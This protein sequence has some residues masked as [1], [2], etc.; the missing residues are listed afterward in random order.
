M[1]RPL[2]WPDWLEDVWAKSAEKGAGGSPE[3]L[4]QHT[5][6]VLERF[7][8]LA[9]LRPT[10]PQ[11]IGVPRLWHILFWAIMIH[12]FGKAACGFQ[13]RLR[14]GPR[15]PYRH[16]VLSLAFI[17][18]IA[19]AF[20]G[21]EVPWVVAAVV[22]HHRDAEEIQNAYEPLEDPYEED[23]V[24]TL[25]AELPDESIRGMWR[26]LAECS[27]DW[28]DS[29]GLDQLG[30]RPAPLPEVEQAVQQI[31]KKGVDQVRHWLRVYRR[32]FK[33][34]TQSNDP[35]L[36]I[37]T[38]ALRGHI[39]NADQSASAHVHSPLKVDFDA[40]TVL[41]QCGMPGDMLYRYPHEFSGGQLQRIAI[42]RALAL[43]PKLLVLD[44]PTSALDVSVQ[45]QIINL[46]QRLQRELEL[47][48][49]FI[50]HDLS[51]V[52]HTS[53]RIAV[54]YLGKIVELSET[55]TLF[56]GGARHPYT[57]AL[58]ASAPMLDPE[59][60][61]ERIVLQGGVPDP[62][63]P[64]PGCAFHPRCPEAEAACA[65]AAPPLIDTGGGHL[66]ACHRI[67]G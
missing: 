33:T 51:V 28:I 48:Y 46:L 30:V 56:S 64:P 38:L 45:A 5:W 41:E 8:D 11:T 18:W 16:E 43:N 22:S 36:I 27:A 4:A 52:Q 57:R 31:R 49:L 24:A 47:T 63:N 29:L 37:G 44:E 21:E 42:A 59:L 60:R 13:A 39:I 62:A 50:S 65:Q 9:R 32:F 3:S 25:I 53:D 40:K 14:G 67:G 54:M 55:A 2:R 26:W 66:V 10:L 12:D 6:L 35:A 34:I 58:L 61:R 7:S 20:T 19:G 1:R 15:W 17:D 23:I